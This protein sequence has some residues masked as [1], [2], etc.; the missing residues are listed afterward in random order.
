[1]TRISFSIRVLGAAL[2]VCLCL[3]GPTRA[4]GG[5]AKLDA[6]DAIDVLSA[7]TEARGKVVVLN[8]WASWCQPCRIEIPELMKVRKEFS[9]NE[10]YLLGVSIDQDKRM[11]ETFVN[12]AGF[13]YPVG[14]GGQEVVEMFQVSGVPRLVVY[15]TEGRLVLNKDGVITAESLSALVRKLLDG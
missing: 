11:F 12:K 15:D 7:V 10:L 8:F 9:E 2:M 4:D 3:M 1:M 13:N 6:M 14:L 5:A